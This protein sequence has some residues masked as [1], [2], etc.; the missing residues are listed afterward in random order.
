MFVLHAETYPGR[1]YDGK[2][3][4]SAIEAAERMTGREVE[5]IYVDKGYQGHDYPNKLR[6]FR[7]A[8]KTWC[9]VLK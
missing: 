1:S 9:S 3:L 4:K 2:T 5:R 8:P 6:V 7:S